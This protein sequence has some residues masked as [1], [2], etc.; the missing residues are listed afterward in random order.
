MTVNFVKTLKT[1]RIEHGV[2]KIHE[3]PVIGNY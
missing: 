3:L 1:S 2:S